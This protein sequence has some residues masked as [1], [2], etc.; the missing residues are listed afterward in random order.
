MKRLLEWYLG[1]PSAEAG[2]DTAWHFHS[3]QPW[4]TWLPDWLVFVL[5]VATIIGVI[6]IY[7]RDAAHVTTGRRLALTALR[8]ATLVLV[9]VF[10]AQLSVSIERTGLPSIAVLIDDS[11]SMS[12]EDAYVN[13]ADAAKAEALVG[14]NASRLELAQALLTS[15][16]HRMLSELAERHKLRFYRFSES[17]VQ[18]GK[19]AYTKGDDFA[20][21]TALLEDIEATGEVTRPGPALLGVFDDF[22]GTP[23]TAIVLLSDGR[24]S[25]GASDRFSAIDASELSRL[26]PVFSVGLGS[27]EPVRDV[28]LF[29]LQVD[30]VAIV[31]DPVILSAKVKSSGYGGSAAQIV[32]KDQ[33]TDELLV[34]DEIR[35]G[36]DGE[37]KPV[38]LVWTPRTEGEYDLK[39]EV[40]PQAS[41]R[42]TDNNSLSRSVSVRAGRIRVLLV[43][44]VPR[45]EFRYLKS[46]LERQSETGGMIE[47]NTVLFD[48][49]LAFAAQDRT[50]EALG[51]RFP[52]SRDQLFEYDIVIFGDVDAGFLS[53]VALE[54]LR[55]F[56]RDHGGGLVLVAGP[57]HNPIS[58]RGTPLE[59]LVP[60][61]ISR[62]ALPQAGNAMPEF[63]PR[64][65]IPAR[66]G[67]TLF[68]FGDTEQESLDIWQ[69]LPP[70]RWMIEAPALRPGA[71]ALVVHPRRTGDEGRLPL[72]V[73][74][75]FGAGKVIFHATDELWLWRRRS[76]DAFYGRYWLQLIRWLSRSRLIGRDRTAELSSDRLIY[77][78][79]E[80]VV[81]RARFLDAEVSSL[82]GSDVTVVIERRDGF[83]REVVLKSQ[84][85]TSV[86]E[87]GL[88][89]PGNGSYHAWIE[90]PSFADT[91]PSTDFRVEAPLR[92]MRDRGLDQQ[93]LQAIAQTTRGRYYSLGDANRLVN[94]IPRGRPV[95]LESREPTRLWNRWELLSLFVMLLAGEWILRKRS[96]LV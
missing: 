54:N 57:L 22:R 19:P 2:Q 30:D 44:N 14:K 33:A 25:G 74:Q 8:L 85:G 88:E 1:V 51:G 56:V 55:E 16:K 20:D 68:R 72:I 60:V 7:R 27:A 26:A 38:E 65:T 5:G 39:F 58:Y 78:S 11:A 92:E 83:R 76:G 46:L 36:A 43:E 91:P 64:L 84:P 24:A 13:D 29:D 34:A 69:Q 23:P 77:Q 6:E 82:A 21:I 50:A 73:R 15:D 18:V 17:A 28:Q 45:W 59:S 67:T 87:G 31:D 10:L 75:Q 95:A 71:T 53:S 9:G 4:P 89:N 93:E 80:K 52:I 48:A 47:V 70:L 61:D 35:L 3:S 66:K 63:R 12:L 41:E 81:L 32:L 37:T 42:N 90:T 86:F 94:D 79:G 96:R 62:V 40:V 49:D